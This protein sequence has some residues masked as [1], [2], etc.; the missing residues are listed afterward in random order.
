MKRI[1]VWLWVL[2][3]LIG[4][5]ACQ[6]QEG[7]QRYFAYLD[8]PAKATL[9]GHINSLVFSATLETHGRSAGSTPNAKL[10]FTSPESLSGICLV[11][12]NEGWL[13]GLDSL[14]GKTDARG[15]GRI[16]ALLIE[17]R[18]VRTAKVEGETV[19]LTL[20][21]GASFILDKK[22]GVPLRVEWNG[23]GRSIEIVV[24]DWRTE[25]QE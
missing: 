16:P 8:A 3:M 2:L 10:T 1:L 9:T 20:S 7:N 15:M 4:S 19:M 24:V 21:D 23:E 6:R 18:A 14:T 25:A 11:H 5:T 12:Q 17:E 13:M 22:T